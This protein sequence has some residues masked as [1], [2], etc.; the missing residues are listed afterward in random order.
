MLRETLAEY[1]KK[2]T[3]PSSSVLFADYIRRW[4]PIIKRKVDEVTY[5]GYE[6]LAN[7]QI[8]P[9]FD[10]SGVR[11]Q[12]V[13]KD[14]LQAYIDEKQTHGRRD[15]KG[16]LSAR[17]LHMHKN[18]LHQ[19]LNEAI[20]DNLLPANPCQFVLLPKQ[21]HYQSHYYTVEQLQTLFDSIRGD[22]LYP[23]IKITALY[24]LRR[25]ELLGLQWDSIDFDGDKLTIQH[26]VSKV[27][28]AVAKDKTKN[29]SSRRSFPLTE[30]ARRIFMDA[31][32]QEAENRRLFGKAYL[33]NNYVFKWDNG[34]LYSPDYITERFSNLLKNHG[35][36]HIRFHD[37]AVIIGLNQN[38][39]RRAAI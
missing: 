35:L 10:A 2:N 5:Q 20:K 39:T 32:K 21:E 19:V 14:V 16:G 8:L 29:A 34:K 1:E 15:G 28:K 17:T 38:P 24:G 3:Q 4:L 36:P 22:P 13:T 7:S 11:L 33:E 18:I 6:I 31:K 37:A 23:L 12:N 27:T 9:Y 26:T 25:S 30:E